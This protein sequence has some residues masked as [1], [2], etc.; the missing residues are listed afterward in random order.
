MLL[1]LLLLLLLVLSSS[2]L[3]SLMMLL[4]FSLLPLL[5]L[6]GT[7]AG[8]R[9]SRIASISAASVL[10]WDWVLWCCLCVPPEIRAAAAVRPAP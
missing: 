9:P 6:E 1:L 3:A 8:C 10:Q 2:A 5:G 4:V 7:A